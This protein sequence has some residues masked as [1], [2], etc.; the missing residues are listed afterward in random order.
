MPAYRLEPAFLC[1][2]LDFVLRK[3]NISVETLH[4]RHFRN[5]KSLIVS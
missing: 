1:G 5:K 3:I 4:S 2:S